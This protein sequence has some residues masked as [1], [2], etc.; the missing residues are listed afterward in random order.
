MAA[1]S[2]FHLQ[3]LGRDRADMEWYCACRGGLASAA[4]EIR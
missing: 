2:I 1:Q 4:I 3:H